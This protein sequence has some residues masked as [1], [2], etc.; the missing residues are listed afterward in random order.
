M[1]KSHCRLWFGP[2]SMCVLPKERSQMLDLR[3]QD[4]ASLWHTTCK[5]QT[6]K[7]TKTPNSQSNKCWTLFNINK[8]K[9]N[10]TTE[11]IQSYSELSFP[12]RAAVLSLPRTWQ[13]LILETVH[14]KKPAGHET[15]ETDFQ[16]LRPVSERKLGAFMSVSVRSTLNTSVLTDGKLFWNIFKDF[17]SVHSM[18]NVTLAVDCQ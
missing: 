16:A 13:K 7:Q 4:W 3:A 2:G 10:F 12:L 5:K 1:F 17:T 8:W 6:K 11:T 18:V 9:T 14:K 15:L